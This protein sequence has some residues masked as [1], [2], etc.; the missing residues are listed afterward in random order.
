MIPL[1][2]IVNGLMTA[3]LARMIRRFRMLPNFFQCHPRCLELSLHE[4]LGLIE[5]VF[6]LSPKVMMEAA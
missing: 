2:S 6:A 3:F 4:E 1:D 5:E